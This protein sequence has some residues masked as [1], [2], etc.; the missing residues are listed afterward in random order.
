MSPFVLTILRPRWVNFPRF[1]PCGDNSLSLLIAVV[2]SFFS[3]LTYS[4]KQ[5]K[6]H[7][8]SKVYYFY[9]QLLRLIFHH[10]GVLQ[11]FA[12]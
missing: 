7:V 6:T 4:D 9:Y 11:A 5:K 10:F 12:V 3:L 2:S 8:V 1:L